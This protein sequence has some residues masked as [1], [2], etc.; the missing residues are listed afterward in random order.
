MNHKL[1]DSRLARLIERRGLGA[2]GV[3]LD[4][5][6]LSRGESTPL[7]CGFSADL[8]FVRSVLALRDR[9][10]E[11]GIRNIVCDAQVQ[12]GPASAADNLGLYQNPTLVVDADA[13][14]F[15][16]AAIRSD[17]PIRSAQQNIDLFVD[18]LLAVS[19]AAD[20]SYENLYLGEDPAALERGVREDFAFETAAEGL[21]DAVL[22]GRLQIGTAG[23]Q[24]EVRQ[25]VEGL[26]WPAEC[27][28]QAQQA[29]RSRSGVLL[30]A[31][32]QAIQQEQQQ[33]SVG[34]QHPGMLRHVERME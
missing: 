18:R 3:Y 25:L 30:A 1:L 22:E 28:P 17:Q 12:W 14:S 10:R 23:Y 6:P 19:Q 32:L 33:E 20:G 34:V 4:A 31:R 26:G 8:N 9:V 13:F 7:W 2:P 29:L 15:T 5:V 21:C 24:A 27:G 11:M 16:D